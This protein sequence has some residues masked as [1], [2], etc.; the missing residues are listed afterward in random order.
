MALEVMKCS[1]FMGI[2]QKINYNRNYENVEDLKAEI[3][4]RI[5][6]IYKIC[7]CTMVLNLKKRVE[8]VVVIK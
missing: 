4:P 7:S 6:K 1:N 2:R 3:F 8:N 5:E